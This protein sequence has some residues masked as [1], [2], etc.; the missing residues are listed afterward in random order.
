[1]LHPTQLAVIALPSER[2]FFVGCSGVSIGGY[3]GG[4]GD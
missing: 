4:N 3:G 1:M 2:A